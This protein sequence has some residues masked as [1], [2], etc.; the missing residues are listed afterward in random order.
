MT[1]LASGFVSR[2]GPNLVTVPFQAVLF[3]FY[4]KQFLPFGGV[5]ILLGALLGAL[6]ALC[7]GLI[8]QRTAP[9][10]AWHTRLANAPL[11]L[12][13]IATGLMIGGGFMYGAMMT[14]ALADPSLTSSVLSALMQPAVPFFI[15]L[16]SALELVVITLIV[17]WNWEAQPKRRAVILIGVAVYL[18]VRVWTYLVFAETRLEISQHPLTESDVA[19]FRQT[20]ATDFRVVLLLVTN[21]CFTLAGFLPA[22]MP[23]MAQAATSKAENA[24]ARLAP[25]A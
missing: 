21:V 23:A 18:V 22:W 10:K 12:G 17:C 4:G 3:G 7:L 6:W 19:W 14:T 5:G 20:L 25:Q 9:R 24:S 11:L 15:V 2:F 13:I 1:A 16:N 8:A